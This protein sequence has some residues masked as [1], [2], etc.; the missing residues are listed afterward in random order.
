M[1]WTGP[2]PNSLT[3]ES[4]QRAEYDANL[5]AQREHVAEAPANPVRIYSRMELV[6]ELRRYCKSTAVIAD[7][8][9]RV[10]SGSRASWHKLTVILRQAADELARY[11]AECFEH[12]MKG[13][14]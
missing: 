8:E 12:R 10:T 1:T 7:Q 3:S 11:D 14:Q 9:I 6:D 5:A 4:D 2:V 13:S